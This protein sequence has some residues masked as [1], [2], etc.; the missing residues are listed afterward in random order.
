MEHGAILSADSLDASTRSRWHSLPPPLQHAPHICDDDADGRYDAR[1]L[2]EQ[3]GSVPVFLSTYATWIDGIQKKLE[4]A[5][6]ES[7][8]P[9]EFPPSANA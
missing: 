4:M 1:V 3:L 8:I 7:S 9:P 5:R 2:R 6:L